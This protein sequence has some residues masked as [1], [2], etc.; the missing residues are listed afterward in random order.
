MSAGMYHIQGSGTSAQVYYDITVYNL[1]GN[2]GYLTYELDEFELYYSGD[3]F[4]ACGFK[5]PDMT[6]IDTTSDQSADKAC[7]ISSAVFA[8]KSRNG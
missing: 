8:P 3:E 4:E 6:E 2:G 5:T 7:L 1:K